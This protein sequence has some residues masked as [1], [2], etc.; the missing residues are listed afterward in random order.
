MGGAMRRARYYRYVFL[1][2]AFWNWIVAVILWFAYKP[3][4]QNLSMSP[5]RY[6]L[7]IRIALALIFVYGIGYFYIYIDLVQNRQIA[8]LG[9]YGKTTVFILFLNAWRTGQIAA[10][11]LI[12]GIVDLAFAIL[13]LEFL[14]TTSHFSLS[15]KWQAFLNHHQTI[16]HT[17]TAITH[18]NAH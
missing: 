9:V 11:L 15:A 4:L 10:P 13:F 16:A 6:L 2:G 5:V 17:I 8:K 3:L 14:I 1:T 7:P 18:K 12:L